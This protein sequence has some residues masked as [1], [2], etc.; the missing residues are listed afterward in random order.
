[1]KKEI[2]IEL[3]KDFH[4]KPLPD[5]INRELELRLPKIK[6]A[7]TIIGPRRAGK[8]FFLF[9]NMERLKNVKRTEILY[10]NLEDDRLLP[11]ELEDMDKIL[12]TYYEIYPENRK[13]MIYLFLDE[14]QNIDG[15]ELFVRRVLD[16]ENAQ[17][18][19]TGSS[20]KLLAK[21]IA[22]SMR[23]RAI[24]YIILP[25]S[26]REFLRVKEFELEK[27]LSSDKKAWLMKYLDEFIRW[28]GFP[29]VVLDDDE[30]SRVRTLKDYV[31]IMLM[32][33]MAERHKIKNITVLRMLFSALQAS[34]SKEFSVH[35]FFNYL[36][37]QGIKISKNTLY[38]YFRY[39]EDAFAILP[40]RRFGYSI[41][42]TEQSIPKVYQIDNGYAGQLSAS[43]SHNIGRLMENLVAVEW[44]RRRSLN[45]KLEFY[46]WKDI[47]GKE[48]DFVIKE[49]PKICEL[50]QVCYDIEDFDT[51]L[52]ETKA[53][54]KASIELKCNNLSVITWDYEETETNDNKKLTYIPL[55]KWLLQIQK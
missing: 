4:E 42:E 53:L 36:K 37:S 39:F 9:N 38:E 22:T 10:V 24:P 48:I 23:G 33:D 11:L 2:A 17:V 13:K 54:I 21:E 43:F 12:K 19:L 6:K 32:R 46:Y 5:I 31:E 3:I 30:L 35:K 52:R 15:W 20:S 14:V 50:V 18:F 7:I 55:W 26:F 27:F 28:G 25:F 29:E 49:G 45:P 41:R 34:F 1:M 44:L 47:S 51:R 8:T 16:S 40:V